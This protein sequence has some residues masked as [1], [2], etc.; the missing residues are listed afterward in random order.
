MTVQN[1]SNAISKLPQG[2]D[3]SKLRSLLE[4]QDFKAADAETRSYSLQQWGKWI[5]PLGNTRK[6]R[7]VS[8]L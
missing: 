4:E 2:L 6:H 5:G 1:I 7:K 8:S 3:F